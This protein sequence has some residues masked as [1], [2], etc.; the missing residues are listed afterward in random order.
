MLVLVDSAGLFTDPARRPRHVAEADERKGRHADVLANFG[1]AGPSR[2]SS[3]AR[4]AQ[5]GEGDGHLQIVLNVEAPISYHV[6]GGG[7][8]TGQV[9]QLHGN[10]ALKA[11]QRLANVNVRREPANVCSQNLRNESRTDSSSAG[12]QGHSHISLP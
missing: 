4:H 10:G 7:E 2:P 6:N 3:A 9:L 8:S 12:C 5:D 1:L 11:E